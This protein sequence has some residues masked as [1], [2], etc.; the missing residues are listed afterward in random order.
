MVVYVDVLIVLNLYINYFLIRAALL[1]MRRNKPKRRCVL[2]ALIGAFGSL[3]I[4]LPELPFV[5]IVLEKILLGAL[6]V[7]ALLGKQSP[8]DF[9][10][11]LLFFLVI[12]F[13]FAGVMLALWTFAAPIG[14]V[15]SNG[16]PYFNIPI[17]AIA[18]FTA[19]AYLLVR[20]IRYIADKRIHCDKISV[21]RISL[22]NCEIELRGLSD[23]GNGLCDIFSGK[24]VVICR[25]EKI[26]PLIPENV[27][28]YFDGKPAESLRVIPCRTI[29]S[30]TLVPIFKAN[31]SIDGKDADGF[32][33]VTKN[34]LGEDVDCIFNPKIIS[35]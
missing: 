21:V 34:P 19:A 22:R 32:V 30:Q 11:H 3:V 16:T 13:M 4:L 18:A 35:L 23:T 9:A 29:A 5:V 6:I 15:Y 33:G 10:I 8:A 12:S 20:L 25:F 17:A 26:A 2:A 24:P 28:N 7:F 31:I 14:M 27:K 1:I